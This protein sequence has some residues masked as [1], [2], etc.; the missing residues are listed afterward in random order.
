MKRLL[1]GGL[2]GLLMMSVS[3]IPALAP[4]AEAAAGPDLQICRAEVT[5]LHRRISLGSA[6]ERAERDTRAGI[7][8]QDQA[9]P[10]AG[11]DL[12]PPGR[13][14][15]LGKLDHA[16]KL[17]SKGDAEGCLDLVG[18][19]RRKLGLGEGPGLGPSAR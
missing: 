14:M 15:L 10:P 6:V 3:G 16:R 13:E 17:A 11:N 12:S 19:V 9:P 7:T 5:S 1:S 18:K 4:S 2:L 8:D